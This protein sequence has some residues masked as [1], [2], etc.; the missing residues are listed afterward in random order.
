MCGGRQPP[1]SWCRCEWG[2]CLAN[3][4]LLPQLNTP[5]ERMHPS[6]LPQAGLSV[7]LDRAK[8]PAP[9]VHTVGGFPLHL[10]SSSPQVAY[11]QPSSCQA[12]RFRKIG[13]G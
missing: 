12:V 11:T 5:S 1:Y 13:F 10:Y 7:L 6:N 8:L 4:L 9:G 3:S 2:E